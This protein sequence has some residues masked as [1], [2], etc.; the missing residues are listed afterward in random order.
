MLAAAEKHLREVD[1]AFINTVMFRMGI[2]PMERT[3]LDMRLALQ[4]LPPDEARRFRRKFRKVW[5]KAMNATIANDGSPQTKAQAS[6]EKRLKRR[7]GVGKTV[8]SR[9]ERNARKKLVYDLLWKEVIEPM[10]RQFENPERAKKAE[11]S[12]T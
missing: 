10:L 2:I 11:A 5:R 3:E 4:Q 7:L 9:A 1:K 6:E 8:P 12:G